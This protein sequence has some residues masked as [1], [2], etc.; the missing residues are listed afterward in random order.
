MIDKMLDGKLKSKMSIMYQ[1]LIRS[2][3]ATSGDTAEHAD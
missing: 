1:R 2:T 3:I